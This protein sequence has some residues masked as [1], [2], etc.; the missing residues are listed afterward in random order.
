M[1]ENDGCVR[2]RALDP[3]ERDF[4]ICRARHD[5]GQLPEGRYGRLLVAR[6]LPCKNVCQM[7]IPRSVIF[8]SLSGTRRTWSELKILLV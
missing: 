6:F 7:T 2:N 1:C 3:Y 5:V 4:R 8:C